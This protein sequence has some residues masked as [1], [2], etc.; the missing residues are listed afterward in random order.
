MPS[1][2]GLLCLVLL[3]LLPG[4]RGQ[5]DFDLADALD[6]AGPLLP[7]GHVDPGPDQYPRPDGNPALADPQGSTVARV[8]TP[9]ASLVL[10]ALLGAGVSY[11]RSPRARSC[12]RRSQPPSA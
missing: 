2:W 12:F 10:L 8:L 1:R 11:F 5:A 4:P 7:P 3:C 6:P 9:V